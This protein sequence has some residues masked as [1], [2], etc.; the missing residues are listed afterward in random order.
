MF[1][2]L[3][4]NHVLTELRNFQ[5]HRI[6]KGDIGSYWNEYMKGA[7]K[8]TKDAGKVPSSISNG[9]K[10]VAITKIS[11]D[12]G[13][14]SLTISR[15]GLYILKC[16]KKS[17]YVHEQVFFSIPPKREKNENSLKY[18]CFNVLHLWPS[19][20]FDHRKIIASCFVS[21]H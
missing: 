21:L 15:W 5:G 1:L 4:R 9:F 17:F 6:L 12:R 13:N 14:N 18:I 8:W 2:E 3:S 16:L 19:W 11:C 7:A 10:W 20:C